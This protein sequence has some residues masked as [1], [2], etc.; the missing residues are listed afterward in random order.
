M[1]ICAANL[2]SGAQCGKVASHPCYGKWYCGRHRKDDNVLAEYAPGL[3]LQNLD[4]RLLEPDPVADDNIRKL[5]NYI[6]IRIGWPILTSGET[7]P[8][9]LMPENLTRISLAHELVNSIKYIQ[10]RPDCYN[11][12]GYCLAQLK[13]DRVTYDALHGIFVANISLI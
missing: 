7:C 5:N 4:F 2:R 11:L 9:V 10:S 3:P 1:H 8:L 12:S 6:N 13:L